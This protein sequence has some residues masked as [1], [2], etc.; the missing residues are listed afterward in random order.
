M[1]SHYFIILGI[2]ILFW[3]KYIKTGVSLTKHKEEYWGQE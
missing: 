3:V 2:F 1:L